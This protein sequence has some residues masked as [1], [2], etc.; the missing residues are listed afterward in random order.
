VGELRP[1][2]P[3]A[4][5]RVGLA[6]DHVRHVAPQTAF[7]VL[8]PASPASPL[9]MGRVG[10]ALGRKK[11]QEGVSPSFVAPCGLA[12]SRSGL[13]ECPSG[14]YFQHVLFQPRDS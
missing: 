3:D 2:A 6:V 5:P 9:G 4:G 13:I 10:K 12:R 1:P 14:P 7:C 8:E 11:N